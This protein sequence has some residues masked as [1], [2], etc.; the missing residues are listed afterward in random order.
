M[1]YKYVALV[2]NLSRL[3]DTISQLEEA[4]RYSLN[5]VRQSILKEIEKINNGDRELIPIGQQKFE[6]WSEGYAAT[7]DSGSAHFHGTAIGE[8]FKDA[9]ISFSN[10]NSEFKEYF[11]PS[12]MTYWGCELFDNEIEARKSFG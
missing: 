6:I 11:D 9:C 5:P 3:L 7:G 2:L 4:H 10:S 8:N 1:S 12:R